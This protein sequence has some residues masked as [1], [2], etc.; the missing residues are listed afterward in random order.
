AAAYG[1]IIDKGGVVRAR[2]HKYLTVPLKAVTDAKGVKKWDVWHYGKNS[3][4]TFLKVASGRW[5][6]LA[7]KLVL[8][9]KDKNFP[10]YGK[11]SRTK[12]TGAYGTKGVYYHKIK[13]LFVYEKQVTVKATYW[14]E[15]AAIYSIHKVTKKIR[16]FNARYVKKEWL[17][18][19]R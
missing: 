11:G 6:K 5:G 12:R 19:N 1:Q 16:K 14:A 17:R 7:G 2:N 18:N 3:K 9:K 13:P 4:Y 15:N 10:T 8:W